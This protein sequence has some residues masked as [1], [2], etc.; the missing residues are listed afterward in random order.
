MVEETP[1]NY[2]NNATYEFD[3]EYPGATSVAIHF[4]TLNTEKNYD[5]LYVYDENNVQ[6]YKVSGSLITDG[7]GD[8]FDRTDG[9]V[10]I[11]GSKIT[12]RLVTDYSVTRYGYKT[13]W[14]GA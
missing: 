7:A 11:P 6:K 4:D 8:V 2:G 1:H 10:V 13:D 3:Y 14:A 9:W 12:V 5:Y